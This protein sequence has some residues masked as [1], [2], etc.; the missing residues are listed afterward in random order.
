[1]P[2]V[3]I[4]FVLLSH[5]V[6]VPAQA[7]TMN[8]SSFSCTGYQECKNLKMQCNDAQDCLVVCAG[9]NACDSANITAPSNANLFVECSSYQSCIYA[10]IY[11]PSIGNL[12]VNCTSDDQSTCVRLEIHVPCPRSTT[13]EFSIACFERILCIL[14]MYF[15]VKYISK[16]GTI[17]A[18]LLCVV[19]VT[20][21]TTCSVTLSSH[22]YWTGPSSYISS[23]NGEWTATGIQDAETY[24][25]KDTDYLYFLS[26]NVR[27][28]IGPTLGSTTVL[29]YCVGT[30]LFTCPWYDWD[31]SVS[32]WVLD[33]TAT[34]ST[35]T[36]VQV[37]LQDPYIFVNVLKTW[38]EA[39]D[40]CQ[41]MYDSH[42]A[43]IE[44]DL[45][46]Q[47]LL[48]GCSF[49]T[50]D[51]LWM[52]LN[53]Q[54]VEG[55]WEYADGTACP[56]CATSPYWNDGEPNNSGDEDCAEVYLRSTIYNMLNDGIC[57]NDQAF[58]C[59]KPTADVL[60]FSIDGD[61]VATVTQFEMT[62][63]GSTVTLSTDD[64]LI[65]YD[66]GAGISVTI[67]M[68]Y[69]FDSNDA[70]IY[71]PGCYR[72]VAMTVDGASRPCYH[73]IPYTSLTT[74]T[75]SVTYTSDGSARN[76]MADVGF[77]NSC[78]DVFDGYTIGIV[79]ATT[80]PSPTAHPTFHPSTSPTQTTS[81]PSASPTVYTGYGYVGCFADDD[82]RAFEYWPEPQV[83]G[84]T[85][86]EC[87]SI[88]INSDYKKYFGLQNGG[89]CFCS[90]SYDLATQYGTSSN[91]P[92]SQLGDIWANDVFEI[93]QTPTAT[94]TKHP[95]DSPTLHPSTSPT[96]A[97]PT[98]HP[99]VHPTT[100]YPTAYPTY[101][102]VNVLK[103]WD[104]A[105][106]YC[107]SMYDSHLAT[108]EDDLS[109]QALLDG[110]SFCTDDFLWMGLN[111]QA[112]EGTWEYADGTAC[113]GCATSPYWNDGEPNNSPGG[114][115]GAGDEDCA[116][117]Y[118][119]P[120][121]T[122]YNMLN[123]GICTNDQAFACNK[124]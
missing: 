69:E 1:M 4:W 65:F 56:G 52:G 58:A 46:A 7:Q 13:S 72:Q 76:I 81:A 53:D 71:C 88:C 111:D 78:G 114:I 33:S 107:Q 85:A 121:Y 86:G 92:P 98:T 17:M 93:Y 95:T 18:C 30:D 118:I 75:L 39:E 25:V 120:G 14:S 99:T 87:Y 90:N 96:T 45:S 64:E 80:T 124:P 40:Y 106:D 42:L 29:R 34:V 9:N 26:L 38:D 32:Q 67:T 62:A 49:C 115:D 83:P 60:P 48:D 59:N 43:T 94:P 73:F 10:Y 89:E 54:A 116:G 41:S 63:G 74:Q 12:I 91:C 44:D 112:V 66:P 110:C 122:I 2:S 104:E 28:Y 15:L 103:T 31:P 11:G 119:A 20:N 117:V 113:P 77:M 109:A 68:T 24:Y 97:H 55:T 47:A 123:D 108:I 50:D 22:Y 5:R 105:E 21:A 8:G 27:W 23:L 101:I 70:S 102:F 82:T 36:C 84:F 100:A 35:S 61:D 37:R 16:Q 6:L 19:H 51:F 79:A 3:F 57:T